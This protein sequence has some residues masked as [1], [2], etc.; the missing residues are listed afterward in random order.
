MEGVRT[1]IHVTT[2]REKTLAYHGHIPISE[3][4]K[5]GENLRVLESVN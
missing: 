5:N 1:I 4:L 2:K 3:M